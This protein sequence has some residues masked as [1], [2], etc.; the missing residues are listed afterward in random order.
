MEQQETIRLVCALLDQ[1]ETANAS[2]LID[3][4]YP[5]IPVKKNSRTYIPR[6]MSKV[7][8]RY[9]FIDRYRSKRLVYPPVLRVISHNL[10]KSFPYHKN[11]KMDEV[12]FAY[13]D[14]YPTIDHIVPVSRGG[15]DN[16]SNWVCC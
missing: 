4:N 6:G 10:P 8:L 13:W 15:E 3:S 2:C 5:F 12:H 9:G 1:S 14:I 16:M 7:F 11:W